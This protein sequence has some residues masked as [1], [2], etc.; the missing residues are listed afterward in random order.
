MRNYF[1][2]ILIFCALA[3]MWACGQSEKPA[4]EISITDLFEKSDR[5]SFKLSPDGKRIAYLG[6]DE[7]C[8]NIFVLDL[9]DQRKSKQ[10]TYQAD[11]NVQYFFW[12]SSDTIVYS[13]SQ[14]AQDSLLLF[15][16]DIHTEEASFLMQPVQATLRWVSPLRFVDGELL[17][18]MNIRDSAVLDL[19]RIPSDGSGPI[20][21]DENKNGLSNWYRSTDGKIRLALSS[22]SVQEVMWYRAEEDQPYQKVLQTD[23]ISKVYPLGPVRGQTNLLYALSNIGRDKFALVK[24]DLT[25]GEELEVIFESASNDLNR[26]GYSFDRQEMLYSTVY[27][28]KK[29][30]VIYNKELKQAFEIIQQQFEDYSID[31]MDVDQGINTILF[32]TYTDVD[33]GALYY[34]HK[35]TNRVEELYRYNPALTD[36]RLAQ[37]KEV[38]FNARDGREIHGYLTYPTTKKSATYPTVVLV[39]DGPNRRDVWGFDAEVQFLASRGYLVFQVNYRGSVG[40]GK[41]FYAAGFKEWGGSIQNDINDGVTWLIHE[42]I[43][44]KDRIAIMG[45]GFGGYS[46]L[47]AACFHPTLYKCVVSSSGYTNLFTYFKEIPPYFQSRVKL[48]HQIIGDPQKE[49][50]LFQ[51]ISPLFHAENIRTPML[52]FQGGRDRHNSPTDVNQFVQRVQNNKVSVRYVFN[53]EEGKR[54]RKEENIVTYYQEVEQFLSTY[55]K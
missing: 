6:L 24:L 3:T 11:I 45:T 34:Y 20:L 29:R 46:A 41:E 4:E 15:V 28:Q 27:E 38:V 51:A 13:N 22:D 37:M 30:T 55:L 32:K 40:F 31:I 25:A 1:G 10:L 49:S 2:V 23:Y 26:D 43:A 39:H 53:P 5:S 7:H 9:E 18:M 54:I 42:G 8:R 17:A 21:F 33:P 36:R 47:Y 44:D 48:Y 14:S 19:Y 12:A 50:E 35:P 16:V 52:I